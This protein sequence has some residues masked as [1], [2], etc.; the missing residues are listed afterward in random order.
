[1]ASVRNVVSCIAVLRASVK[2]TARSIII[3]IIIIIII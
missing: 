2:I 3:I 1:M